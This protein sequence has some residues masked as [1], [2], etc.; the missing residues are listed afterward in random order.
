MEKSIDVNWEEKRDQ[1]TAVMK[2]LYIQKLC[3][4][5]SSHT[6]VVQILL[7]ARKAIAL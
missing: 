1:A 3:R 5:L 2:S 7:N 6:V 4:A